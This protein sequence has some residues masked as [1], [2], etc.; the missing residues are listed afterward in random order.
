MKK[1]DLTYPDNLFNEGLSSHEVEF[2]PDHW[3][4]MKSLLD[5]EDDL[6]PVVIFDSSNNNNKNKLSNLILIIMSILSILTAIG[7]LM[8]STAGSGITHKHF[9]ASGS[10]DTEINHS[11]TNGGFTKTSP[12]EFKSNED[13]NDKTLNQVDQK[14]SNNNVSSNSNKG[15]NNALST[16]TSFSKNDV[17]N[18]KIDGI[19]LTK[20]DS[21]LMKNGQIISSFDSSDNLII[22]DKNYRI[23]KHY[24][25][26]DDRY[27]YIER[28]E[29]KSVQDGF[30]GIHFTAEKPK[31][32]DSFS[33]GF[34][35][36]LMSGN[37][38]KSSHWGLYAGF[39]FGMQF[40]GKGKTSGVILNNT[41]QDSGFTKLRS[42]AVDLL[43]RAHFEYAK[44]PVI[45]YFNLAA[46]PRLYNTS[47]VVGSYTPLQNTESNTTSNSV[48]TSVSMMYGFGAG[49]RIRVSPVVSFDIRYER[50]AGTPVKKVNMNESQFNGLQYDLKIEKIKPQN[51]QIKF[52]LLFD[53]SERDYDKKII[54]KGHYQL[55]SYD[56]IVTDKNDTGKVFIPCNCLPCNTSSINKAT[57]PNNNGNS[58]G[59]NN[60]EP[61][62]IPSSRQKSSFPEIKPPSKPVIKPN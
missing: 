16:S 54:E 9:N 19:P 50:F 24:V 1:K 32:A 62:N 20:I 60:S 46:G 42:S 56:T 2:N 17:S 26:Y 13:F 33:S 37:R 12:S 35:V 30:I 11:N 3:E 47:Q 22:G 58:N 53:I 14:P 44:Y 18:V 39:D 4:H 59:R 55:T 29:I 61:I 52:G 28:N 41:N 31:V 6:T 23:F 5:E 57:T 10:V 25:W 15:K 38:L 45:P 49:L 27:E 36:Q 8:Y 48:H 40:F 21:P 34:N 7:T 51:E 43:G